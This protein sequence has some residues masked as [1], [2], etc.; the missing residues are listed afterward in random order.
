MEL[1]TCPSEFQDRITAAGGTNQYGDPNFKVAWTENEFY[2]AGG[3]WSGNGQCTF[4]GY[5]EVPLGVD[6]GWGLF[7]YQPADKY[8]SAGY[9][10]FTN[11]DEGTGLQTLGEYPYNG[12]Y[13]M[14]I[15]LTHRRFDGKRVIVE[16][17]ELTNLLVDFII[18]IIRAAEHLSWERRR[19]LMLD[20]RERQERE[21]VAQIEQRLA[22][23]YP[24]FGM[25]SRSAARL[26]CNSVVQK[27]A[28][29]I[30]R[31]WKQAVRTIKSRGK[32][33]SA[34]ASA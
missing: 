27:K 28:E 30:E 6:A 10:Y 11:Y 32:G 23:A 17:M 34:G 16:Q 9:Y 7:Q 20:A 26:E 31:Y 4:R 33:L 21:Q 22:D 5:R 12:R 24:S 3:E 13:E 14:V 15:P 25:A 1:H 2:K 18:P 8:G 29:Q 19:G